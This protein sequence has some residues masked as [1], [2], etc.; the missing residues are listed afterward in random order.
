LSQPFL[1]LHFSLFIISEMLFATK[2]VFS[3]PNRWK[4]LGA[5]SRLQDGCSRSPHCT[6]LF[7]DPSVLWAPTVRTISETS[8]Y[9]ALCCRVNHGNTLV[10]LLHCLSLSYSSTCH[11]LNRATWSGITCDFRT[12]LRDFLNTVMNCFIRQTLPTVNRKH[13]FK[14]IFGVEPSCSHTKN[15]T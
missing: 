14:S 2:V 4:S 12:S 5:K 1:H 11:K 7:L 10:Q 15:T 6:S 9:H 8:N 13:F 3:G